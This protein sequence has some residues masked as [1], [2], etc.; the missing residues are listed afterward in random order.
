MTVAINV[1]L[2]PDEIQEIGNSDPKWWFEQFQFNN[3]RSPAHPGHRYL[4]RHTAAKRAV[5]LPWMGRILPGKTVL[6]TFCANGAFSFEAVKLGAA[7]VTGVDFD[8]P[9]IECASLVAKLAEA[10]GWPVVPDFHAVDIYDLDNALTGTYD[11]SMCFGGLYHVADPAYVL[12]LIRRMTSDG[13]YL[14]L[15]T[16]GILWVPGNVSRFSIRKEDRRQAGFTSWK[17]GSG[18]WTFTW[19]QVDR[20]LEHAGF[21]VV[22]RRFPPFGQRR[23]LPSYFVLA[24]AA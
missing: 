11:V 7:R 23:L 24:E 19:R 4:E 12:T 18:V 9:R 17:A 2:S 22:E 10:H 21:R 3:A 16:S 20:L 14:L 15:Q 6:D 1:T 5:L 13:G 8:P